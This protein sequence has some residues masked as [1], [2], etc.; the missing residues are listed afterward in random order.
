ML[1][2]AKIDT[3]V[4]NG[5][6][7]TMERPGHRI[8][9]LAISNGRIA[10]RGTTSAIRELA[11]HAQVIDCEGRTVL[12]G[13]IDS[14]CHP[15]MHGARLGRWY[16]L[17]EWEIATRD[18]LLSFV[19]KSTTNR[20]SDEWLTAYRFD[21]LTMGGY[22]TLAQLD[23]AAGGRPVFLYRR[24]ALMGLANSA[25]LRSIG[26]DETSEDPPFGRIEREPETGRL[27]GLLRARAAHMMIEHI[28]KD[29][30]ADDFLPGMQRVLDQYVSYGI[31]SLHNSLTTSQAITCYQRMRD[32]G[33]LKIRAGLLAT[34][35][36]P[37]LIKALLRSR[38]QSGFGDEW[39]RLIAVEWVADGSTSGRTAAYYEPYI[40]EPVVG[41][42]PN[43]CGA[44]LFD[45]KELVEKV[46]EAH[47]AGL[48]VCVDGMGDRGID[49]ILDAFEAVLADQ[50]RPDH[51]M[52]IE[53]CCAVTPGI[54][55]RLKR[56]GVVASTASGF[57]YDLGDAHIRNRGAAAMRNMWP[58]RSLIDAGVPAPCHS[59]SPVCS[60]N[61][62]LGM[63][64]L[65]NRR[66]TSGQDLDA[67]QAITVQEALETY[68]RL[69][70]WAGREEHI[71][72]DLGLGKLADLCV[73]DRDPLAIP[74]EE[75]AN[76][77]VVKTIV[78]G[79]VV[80]ER[81]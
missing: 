81:S 17:S 37:D 14:H 64:A 74:P 59:D 65:V 21:D 29:Y 63:S 8:E 20:P 33:T 12:P 67:S 77:Q 50:P 68:T 31:T 27:T 22:P 41:E 3:I 76:V 80:F 18:D 9:A 44:V 43:N 19:R 35:R 15:D 1:E 23:S 48:T 30:T 36:E 56:S 71:K 39:V 13:L 38:I 75:L 54:V 32:A 66:T 72:G 79:R 60:V 34:G 26:F 45:A 52:R 62:F 28:Q 57:A 25:A 47:R 16:D 53:H 4:I 69:G 24:D 10:A 78:D 70:A 73:V 40:G 11:P 58:L 7:I 6:I 49:F 46:A 42:P 61:P 5:N 55:Q 51:R 2:T